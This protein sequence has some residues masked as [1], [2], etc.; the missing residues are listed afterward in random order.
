MPQNNLGNKFL[1]VA[2]GVMSRTAIGVTVLLIC[3]ILAAIPTAVYA[4][5]STAS[6]LIITEADNGKT[7]NVKQ[8]QTFS[9]K[10]NENPSTGYSWQ[11]ELSSGLKLLSDKYYSSQSSGTNGR[12][13]VGAGGYHL[14]VIQAKNKGS[15]Q[16]E[17]TY[18]RPWEQAGIKT[19]KLNVVVV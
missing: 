12:I 9:L 1:G 13:F 3:L 10:L 5:P 18:E 4:K 14:W 16:V 17:A 2:G 11:L 19:F 7:I 8:G 15:Q 6:Q